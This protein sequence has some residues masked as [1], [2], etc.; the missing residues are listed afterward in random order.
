M[1]RAVSSKG[2]GG[3]VIALQYAFWAVAEQS[4]VQAWLEGRES[5]FADVLYCSAHLDEPII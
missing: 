5:L 2:E 4:R 1:D 3:L